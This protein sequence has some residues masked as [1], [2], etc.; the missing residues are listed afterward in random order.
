MAF[1]KG[2]YDQAY[3]RENITRKFIPFNKNTPE[4]VTLL[5][6]INRQPNAT[7]YI[8]KLV[9]ED[10]EKTQNRDDS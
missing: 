10:M 6:W 9:R 5:E 2:K 1:D 8:K 4:D 7:A 3:N